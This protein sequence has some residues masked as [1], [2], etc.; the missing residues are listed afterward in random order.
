MKKVTL[1]NTSIL[2][3]FG[4]FMYHEISLEEAQEITAKFPFQSA[5]GHESTAEI[6][7]KLL[8]Q[9]VKM[10]RINFSQQVG[11]TAIIFK[12]NGRPPEGVILTVLEIEKIGYSFGTLIRMD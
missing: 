6:L 10:N 11:E 1:L 8:K 9:D 3:A 2:T 12:L 5:I 7:S 4:S